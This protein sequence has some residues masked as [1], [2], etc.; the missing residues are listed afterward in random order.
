MSPIL[1]ILLR[2]TIATLVAFAGAGVGV[3]VSGGSKSK[4]AIL[5]NAAL[6]ALLSVAVFDILPDAKESLNWTQLATGTASGFVLFWVIGK[7]VYPVCPA[8]AGSQMSETKIG[9]QHSSVLSRSLVL[10]MVTLGIHSTMD[11]AAVVIGDE[12]AH[13]INIPIFFAVSFHK[14]PEGMALLLLLI[15]A[16]YT[17]RS[18]FFWTIGIETTTE[19][20]ALLALLLVMHLNPTGLGLLSANIA[21]GFIYLVVNTFL[22]SHHTTGD[23]LS[24]R[25][26]RL[27]YTATGAAFAVTGLIIFVSQLFEKH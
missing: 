24:P 8:C 10:M 6:G 25:A 21:G 22:F 20:G 16:G 19:I 26:E 4:L 2:T 12:M 15:G 9:S 5:V 1:P 11:G 14:F 18:A 17:K 7:Y 27:K 13:G 3:S 23:Q